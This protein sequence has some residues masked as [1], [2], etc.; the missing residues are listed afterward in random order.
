MGSHDGKNDQRTSRI[1]I[2][3]TIIPK[4]EFLRHFGVTNQRFVR[5][6]LLA[7]ATTSCLPTPRTSI[8][9]S[10]R[11]VS[12]LFDLSLVGFIHGF[13]SLLLG[14]KYHSGINLEPRAS[15]LA[16]ESRMYSRI[17]WDTVYLPSQYEWCEHTLYKMYTVY[18]FVLNYTYK[19]P[20]K[21]M[22]I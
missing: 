8:V 15:E 11:E 4:P 22:Y 5:Y 7:D 10:F 2:N 21:C 3:L 13:W 1:W 16:H 18:I 14:Q 12:R 19:L 9:A 20:R 17:I 6:A